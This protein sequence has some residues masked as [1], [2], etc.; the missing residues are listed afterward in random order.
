MWEEFRKFVAKGNLVDLAVAFI[1]AHTC[2]KDFATLVYDW[3][4]KFIGHVRD[5]F[6]LIRPALR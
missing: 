6:C 2:G 5:I 4:M 3:W 1:K